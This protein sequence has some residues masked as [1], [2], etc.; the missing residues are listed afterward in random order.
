[1]NIRS[2]THDA[3]DSARATLD[4]VSTASRR[5]V[6]TTEWATVALIAVAAVSVLALG[7]A[8]AAYVRA[9]QGVVK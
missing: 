5:V 2:K 9:G 6:E 4:D 1:M 3:L 7:L 8:T